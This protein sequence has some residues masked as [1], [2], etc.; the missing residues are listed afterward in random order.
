MPEGSSLVLGINGCQ[1]TFH[2]AS[3]TLVSAG[4]LCATV[5]E[6]RF[7]RIKHSRGVPYLS[8]RR[9][10]DER[11]LEPKD[12]AAIGFYLDPWLMLRHYFLHPVQAFFPESFDLF[13]ALPFYI[14]LLRTRELLRSALSVPKGTPIY[15]VRHHLCHA[16]AAYYGSEFERAA[17]LVVDGSGERETSSYYLGEG[18]SLRPIASPM[19]YPTSIGFFYEGIATHIGLGWVG[20]A[21]KMMGL[22]PF[23]RP[24][25]YATLRSWFDFRDDGSIRID[26][27]KMGYYLNRMFFTAAGLEDIG[28]GREAHQPILQEHADLAA[29]AQ[30]IL[31]EVVVHL[32]SCL[33]KHTKADALCYSGGV[34][35]NIDAN[36]ALLERAGFKD[37]YIMPA[38]YDGGTSI[39]AAY[40]T[41]AT[42]FPNAARPASLRRADL[43]TEYSESA[44]AAALNIAALPYRRFDDSSLIQFVA[45][46]LSR[47]AVIGWFRGRMEFGPRALGFRSILADP[48]ERRM[49]DYLNL[50]VKGRETYRPFAPAVP[51]ELADRYFEM[52]APSPFMLYKFV[53]RPEYR[54]QLEAITHVDGSARVQT[55]APAENPAFHELLLKFGQ[56]SGVPVLLNT[57]FNLAGEP[58]V[59]TPEQ[60]I[61]SFQKSG[62]DLL[63]L[64]NFVVEMHTTPQIHTFGGRPECPLGMVWPGRQSELQREKSEEPRRF[65]L[66]LSR[67]EAWLSESIDRESAAGF[68]SRYYRRSILAMFAAAISSANALDRRV[69]RRI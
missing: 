60:A 36:S 16:A 22:A 40:A 59:E 37:V 10:L 17:V 46:R 53:V 64:G 18:K 24:R 68:F 9:I 1:D 28:P 35:L 4:T 5:E 51:L 55:V 38:A 34:A 49:A 8:A 11:G 12:L 14:G 44:M 21:G 33:K 61:S 50:S 62:M 67:F 47:G 15:F 6:E 30:K 42:V 52:L 65:D 48:R 29:S 41:Y 57:S 54:H 43:G 32:G 20:G 23:G 31:E 66:P 69:I 7:N 56:I 25:K 2:D 26:L 63:V 39:G 3:A 27:R 58:L 13:Q 45:Q 19:C